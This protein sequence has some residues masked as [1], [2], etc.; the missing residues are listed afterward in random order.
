MIE[1]QINKI[2]NY[3]TLTSKF[4]CLNGAFVHFFFSSF[5]IVQLFRFRF[6]NVSQNITSPRDI[7]NSRI[8]QKKKRERERKLKMQENNFFFCNSHGEQE[9]LT[10][11]V[12]IFR[13]FRYDLLSTLI[14]F[15]LQFFLSL[16]FKP[17]RL[18]N[19]QKK[20]K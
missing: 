18:R 20:T 13:L 3:V 2:T 19:K 5:Q 17:E 7:S 4:N 12:Y 15:R 6:L 16:S 11:S 10:L 9:L 14:N 1:T 8:T